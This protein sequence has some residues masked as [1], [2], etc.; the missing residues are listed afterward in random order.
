MNL[1][2]Q[3]TTKPAAKG[4]AVQQG[5][6]VDKLAK[7]FS[8]TQGELHKLQKQLMGL[9]QVVESWNQMPATAFQAY[10]PSYQ[11]QGGG[12]GVMDNHNS[13][14][15]NKVEGGKVLLETNSLNNH[16]SKQVLINPEVTHN[17]LN[18]KDRHR[19]ILT[20]LAIGIDFVSGVGIMPLQTRLTI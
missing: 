5:A 7:A 18:S 8:S 3:Q 20:G 4:S 16:N 1:S 14:S 17:G 12:V 11:P 10:V 6:D 13:N 9:T 2:Q 19:E 15:I